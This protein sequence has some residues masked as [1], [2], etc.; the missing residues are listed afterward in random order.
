ML[1][2][3]DLADFLYIE[4]QRKREDFMKNRT[5]CFSKDTCIL[6]ADGSTKYIDEVKIGE[7]VASTEGKVEE[8]CC[9]VENE[10]EE[11]Y[12]LKTKQ[13]HEIMITGDHP[14]MTDGDWKQVKELAIGNRL[15]RLETLGGESAYEELAIIEVIKEKRKMYNLICEDCAI[16]ANGFVCSD[17][18]MQYK[19]VLFS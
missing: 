8:V 2:F 15:M 7:W 12:L 10:V 17:F 16:I 9:D 6:M 14:M 5:C 3:Q 13:G 4:I 18:H 11:V 1:V 19:M